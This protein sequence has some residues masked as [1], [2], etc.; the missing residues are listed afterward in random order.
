MVFTLSSGYV[1]LFVYILL[2]T[3]FKEGLIVAIDVENLEVY[4]LKCGNSRVFQ[5]EYSKIDCLAVVIEY[6]W[7]FNK[8][9]HVPLINVWSCLFQI[10]DH[11]SSI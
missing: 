8:T 9:Q 7:Y 6:S 2:F 10:L 11:F 1:F 4:L 3:T 5:I